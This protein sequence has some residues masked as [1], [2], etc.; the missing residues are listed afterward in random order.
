MCFFYPVEV[1]Q[2][3]YNSNNSHFGKKRNLK[4]L[5]SMPCQFINQNSCSHASTHETRGVLYKHICAHCFTSA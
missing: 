3:P 4:F 1:V 5:K 2:G